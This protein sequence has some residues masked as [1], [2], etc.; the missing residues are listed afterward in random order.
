LVLPGLTVAASAIEEAFLGGEE[1][2]REIAARLRDGILAFWRFPQ[3]C[4]RSTCGPLR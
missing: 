1:A 2:F 4:L 3:T